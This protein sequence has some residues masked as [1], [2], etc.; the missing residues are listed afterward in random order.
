MRPFWQAESISKK[1]IHYR[2]TVLQILCEYISQ[3]RLTPNLSDLLLINFY[4]Y[5]VD[6]LR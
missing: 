6:H 4:F 2:Y 5:H 3:R 1:G